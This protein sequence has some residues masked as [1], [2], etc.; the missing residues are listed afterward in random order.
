MQ[1]D[2]NGW[3]IV[4][5]ILILITILGMLISGH[6]KPPEEIRNEKVEQRMEQIRQRRKEAV[7]NLIIEWEAQEKLKG[8]K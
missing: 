8:G 5:G 4:I 1:W 7:E 2:K 3:V 6:T